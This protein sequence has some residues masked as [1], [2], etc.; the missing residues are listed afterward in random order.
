MSPKPDQA[1]GQTLMP[2]SASALEKAVDLAAAK[3]IE[4]IPTERIFDQWHAQRCPAELLGWLAWAVSVDDWNPDWDKDIKRDVIA[5]NI[6]AHRHKGTA[7]SIK[8]VLA[9]LAVETQ[10]SEWQE[11]TEQRVP[12]SFRVKALANSVLHRDK[13]VE[14]DTEFYNTMQRQINHNKPARSQFE[15]Q[16]G[17]DYAS[18]IKLGSAL[19]GT[20]YR[21]DCARLNTR[22]VVRR[23]QHSLASAAQCISVLRLTLV[24][25]G[26]VAQG[27]TQ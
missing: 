19:G 15:L 25:Q 22:P 2:A 6:S 8:K 1:A 23:L 5:A 24:A 11:D 4:A 26:G 12:H 14:L 9:S 21:R 13:E 16:V 27:G 20:S 17:A 10:L 18:K 7:H 3:H